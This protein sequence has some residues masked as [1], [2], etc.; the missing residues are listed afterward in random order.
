MKTVKDACE[1]QP[2]ALDVRLSD[3]VEQLDELINAEGTGEAFF[4]RTFITEG[5]KS[6]VE[7]G[8][9]RLAGK[10][11]SAIFH[12]KQAMGGGKTH[13]L[14]SFGLLAK[15]TNLRE[16][17]FPTVSYINDF[18]SAKVAAFNGRNNPKEFFW[19]GIA[20]QLG[21]GELFTQFWVSGPQAPDEKAWLKLFEGDEPILILLDEMPPYFHYYTT[22]KIG[23][24]TI[25]DIITRAFANLLTAAGKKK[26]VA[27]VVSDLSAAY[28]TGGKLINRALEDARAE[29]GRQERSI[30]PVDLASNEA[31]RPR[32][33]GEKTLVDEL[34]DFAVDVANRCLVP[35][36]IEE[37]CWKNLLNIERFYLKMLELEAKGV[38]KL[39]TYQNFAKAFKIRNFRSIMASARANRARL[40]SSIE[41]GKSEMSE[42]SEFYIHSHKTVS[43]LRAVL[44]ALME[45]QKDIESEDV[46]AHL[47]ENVPN[48]Y[49]EATV[50]ELIIALCEFIADKVQTIRPKE[51]DAAKV[52]AEFIKNQRIG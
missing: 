30:T 14:V 37:K 18:K 45:L 7:E 15:Y 8:I 27:V 36:G 6:L 44:Y 43:P 41:L 28:D 21:R 26:N 42:G 35:Q 38:Q 49:G 12:L 40:K 47:T 39:D 31:L 11:S 17:Y 23:E 19:G 52:L 4:E 3:Q 16:K 22:Q 1:L 2:N 34:I 10:S 29:L 51:A 20:R 13:L 50:R 48:Y 25:A 33:R 5:M 32:V 9:A 24:G 46:L